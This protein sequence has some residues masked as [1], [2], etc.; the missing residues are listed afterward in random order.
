MR[1]YSEKVSGAKLPKWAVEA[2]LKPKL[3]NGVIF[4]KMEKEDQEVP[5]RT[6]VPLTARAF[7]I[8]SRHVETQAGHVGYKRTSAKVRQKYVWGSKAL[9]THKVMKTCIVC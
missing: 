2:G 9:H 3:R 4:F 5:D 6:F 7:L 1:Q 8:Q